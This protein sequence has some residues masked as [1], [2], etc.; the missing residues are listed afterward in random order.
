MRSALCRACSPIHF[1]GP[2]DDLGRKT[3]GDLTQ[4]LCRS[5]AVVFF[6]TWVWPLLWDWLC[7]EARGRITSTQSLSHTHTHTLSLPL[8]RTNCIQNSVRPKL[9][10]GPDEIDLPAANNCKHVDEIL[11]MCWWC[12][13]GAEAHQGESKDYWRAPCTNKNVFGINTGFLR[14]EN[15]PSCWAKG[16]GNDHEL[17]TKDQ[18]TKQ[19]KLD[20]A[21]R[22]PQ[23]RC[24]SP[25][26]PP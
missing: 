1:S 22:M 8:T 6:Q 5:Q 7:E 9:G 24:P 15:P 26:S 21:Q 25:W 17:A 13:V 19:K 11:R 14:L 2:P 18:K 4:R 12:R 23:L 10:P 3:M 20:H 16:G